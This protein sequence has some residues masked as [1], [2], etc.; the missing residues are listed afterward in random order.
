MIR[1]AHGKFVLKSSSGKTL[2]THRTKRAAQ[3]QETAINMAKA[4]A[5][6]HH[7]P[8]PPKGW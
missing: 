3:A 7:L 1:K 2:G 6:G 8:A 4:R 5:A